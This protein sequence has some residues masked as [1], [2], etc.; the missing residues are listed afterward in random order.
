MRKVLASV[1][2]VNA[3][4]LAT[5]VWQELPVAQG[6][7][8]GP[9]TDQRFCADSNGDG[10]VDMSDAIT[11]LS[12]LFTGLG[13]P[14]YCIAEGVGLD[15]FATKEELAALRGEMLAEINSVRALTPTEEE[16]E[17]LGH[18]SIEQLPVDR[19][20]AVTAKTVRLSGVNF[21]IVNGLGTTNGVDND[22]DLV[23]PR[24]FSVNG[25]GNLIVG[26]N[27]PQHEEFNF[28]IVERTGSH[29][30]VVGAG[31][32]YTSVAGFVGGFGN[33]I[34]GPFCSV[35]GG[36]ANTAGGVANQREGRD[37]ILFCTVVGGGDNRAS[38]EYSA[39]LG[40]LINM[41]TGFASSVSGG[42]G[43]RSEGR[44]SS[45]GGGLENRATDNS[46]TVSGGQSNNANGHT[47]HIC[48][49]RNNTTT[50]QASCVSGGGGLLANSLGNEAVGDYSTVSGGQ[51][52]TATEEGQH[53]P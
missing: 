37:G 48:G 6:G 7:G 52:L 5:R 17:I 27:E 50:G 16:R 24:E 46:S 44:L 3:L 34:S 13:G 42:Q 35:L 39:V 14:P 30:V 22:P 51:G 45:I 9:A 2:A 8:G 38:A 19:S 11:I 32:N 33:M 43:N 36:A 21:Q 31:H 26:Y 15:Q 49:G 12:Y 47:S 4:L 53:L 29:N 25:V 1:L 10:A 23:V 28:G 41:T 18:M 20:G 40:G